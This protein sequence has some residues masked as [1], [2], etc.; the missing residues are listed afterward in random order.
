MPTVPALT[1]SLSDCTETPNPSG[2]SQYV[3]QPFG[4]KDA[5]EW[6]C[7]QGKGRLAEIYP[8]T[9]NAN[10]TLPW[11]QM[12]WSYRYFEGFSFYGLENLHQVTKQGVYDID[13]KL[14]TKTDKG[15]IVYR[16]FLVD[17]E[18][19]GYALHWDSVHWYKTHSTSALFLDGLG[20]AGDE[21][22]NLNGARFGTYDNDVNG[23]ARANNAGWWFNPLGCTKLRFHAKGLYWP[24]NRNGTV[25]MEFVDV[26][27]MFVKK[28]H[29]YV[30]D[31]L[32][33]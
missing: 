9:F 31:D 29:W 5:L 33:L 11:Q 6:V 25:T 16:N 10:Y 21:T 1:S 12:K 4:S 24:T 20:G 8:D 2:F 23:C 27:V 18:A 7:A 13:I 28:N 26:V 3:I 19:Q 17:S 14:F 15:R 30:E 32:V 22:K